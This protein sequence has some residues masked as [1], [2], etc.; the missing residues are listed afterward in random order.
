MTASQNIDGQLDGVCDFFVAIYSKLAAIFGPLALSFLV[1]GMD[2]WGAMVQQMNRSMLAVIDS[3]RDETIVF[4]KYDGIYYPSV[5]KKNTT[6]KFMFA[7]TKWIYD[8]HT[9]TF[10]KAGL[11]NDFNTYCI[12]LIGASLT[13]N[14]RIYT[15]EPRTQSI[16]D[17]SEWVLDQKIYSTDD[18]IPL[19][20][21]VGAWA[22]C[23][24]IMLHYNYPGYELTVMTMDGDE[25]VYDLETEEELISSNPISGS[26]T[27][28]ETIR[29]LPPSPASESP[30]E[31]EEP[32]E[33]GEI[34][35]P[36]YSRFTDVSESKDD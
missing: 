31:S 19:Q 13:R 28:C 24:H 30:V 20:V 7:Y 26:S 27:E 23:K 1:W 6:R 5:E 8:I 22:Y 29:R 33:E 9:K 25:K 34:P 2:T 4:Y 3:F 15:D 35:E 16:G 17:L 18:T 10:I 12:P 14:V 21:L 32:L 36:R 11:V